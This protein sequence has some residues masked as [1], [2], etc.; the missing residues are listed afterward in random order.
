MATLCLDIFQMLVHGKSTFPRLNW[1]KKA[2]SMLPA[3]FSKLFGGEPNSLAQ[4]VAREV[5]LIDAFF[6]ASVAPY[7]RTAPE[8][9]F[10]SLTSATAATTT[11]AAANTASVKE[12]L[13]GVKGVQK[14][15]HVALQRLNLK[16]KRN[17]SYFG[18]RVGPAIGA[19]VPHRTYTEAAAATGLRMLAEE[20]EGGGVGKGSGG[21]AAAFAMASSGG[22]SGVRGK[23]EGRVVPHLVPPPEAKWMDSVTSQ[24]K[25]PLGAAVTLSALLSASMELMKE[26][27]NLSFIHKFMDSK[28]TF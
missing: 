26:Y 9:P 15:V 18:E 28:T 20:G 2:N 21:A 24:L 23:Y 17:Q 13:D 10:P 14:F 8:P 11:A 4:G 5:M 12:P 16:N 25:D 3:A 7:I 27:A 6:H 22:G 19:L 1:I